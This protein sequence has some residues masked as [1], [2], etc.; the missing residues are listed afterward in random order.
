MKGSALQSA[1]RNFK[2]GSAKS[3]SNCASNDCRD[4]LLCAKNLPSELLRLPA[5]G[6]LYARLK[7]ACK[8]TSY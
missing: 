7:E 3:Y 2:V 6:T 5:W 4:E 8:Q 1:Y